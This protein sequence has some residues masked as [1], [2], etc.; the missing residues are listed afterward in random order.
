MT[1]DVLFGIDEDI[2]AASTMIAVSA[3][4]L[5]PFTSNRGSILRFK[6]HLGETFLSFPQES[7]PQ[8]ANDEAYGFEN[9]QSPITYELL[10]G[11]HRSP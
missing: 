3:S 4:R 8:S 10:N 9:E 2:L 5:A 11:H 6:R 7:A 1:N